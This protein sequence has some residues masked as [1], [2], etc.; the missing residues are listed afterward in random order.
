MRKTIRLTGRRQLPLNAFGFQIAE[1]KGKRVATLTISDPVV[2]RSFPPEAEIRVKLVENKLVEI[3]RFGTVARPHVS[4]DVVEGSFRTPSCQIRVV[5][6]TT[7][8]QGL[9]LGT[10]PRWTY[11][12]GGDPDGILDFQ[13]YATAPRT[14]KLEIKSEDEHPIL[15]VDE[16]I[17]D[18]ALWAKS[19]P[20]FIS[21]V[22]PQIIGE[23]MSRI[24]LYGSPPEDGWMHDW[25]KWAESLA[26]GS[27]PPFSDKID[28]EQRQWIDQLVEAFAL[29]HRLAD[30]VIAG[31][32]ALP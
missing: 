22:F 1:I 28:D 9:L 8:N 17:P 31:F 4:A 25:L 14:W 2:I 32:E 15:Y 26:P 23:I 29:R 21:C 30:Q 10:T 12:S 24:I 20:V 19:D 27:A 3:L 16:R 5:S 13:P 18:A 11:K 7:S 6:G